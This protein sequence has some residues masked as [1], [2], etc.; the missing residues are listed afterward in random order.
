MDI[1]IKIKGLVSILVVAFIFT[2]CAS[3]KVVPPKPEWLQ[4]RPIN[5][6]YY[7]GIGSGNK[8]AN[9]NGY[10]QS[11]KNNALNDLAGEIRVKISNSSLL[12]TLAVNNS[13]NETFDSKTLTSTD[14]SLE[15]YELVDTFEDQNN[16]WVY[17]KLSKQTY[18]EIKQQRIQKAIDNA[19]SKYDKGLVFKS[20]QQYYNAFILFIKAIEDVKPYLTEQLLTKYQGNDIYLGNELF[21]EILGI[22]NQLSISSDL[23]EITVKKGQAVEE[24]LLTFSVSDKAGH[25]IENI[26]IIADF[27]A[28]AMINDKDRTTSN[29]IVSFSIPKVKTKKNLEYFTAKLDINSLLQEATNDFLIRK[30]VRNIKP[31]TYTKVVNILNPVFFVSSTENKLARPDNGTVLKEALNSALTPFSVNI[32]RNQNDADF[33]VE[34]VSDTRYTESGNSIY[35]VSLDAVVTVKNKES[36]VLYQRNMNNINA[37]QT[38]YDSAGSDAYNAAVEYIK[39]RVVPDMMEQLF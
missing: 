13:V 28:S 29:G 10:Q 11:A 21:N 35:K 2:Q 38:S 32:T 15:G 22:L 3:T 36:K 30:L 6:G 37:V 19:L 16:Y 4:N 23:K 14:E 12:Y 9:I 27:T 8:K 25:R 17:Y 24:E 5:S 18:E 26:P 33:W 20:Q 7:I 31:V 34:I 1:R 39:T